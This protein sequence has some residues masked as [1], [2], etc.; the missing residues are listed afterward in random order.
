MGIFTRLSDIINSNINA[1][2]DH[3]EDPEKI[4]RMIIQEMEDTLVEAR[5]TAARTIAERKDAERQLRRYREAQDEW[6]RKAEVALRKGREDLSKAA[7]IEKSKLGESVTALETELEALD[8]ALSQGDA[9]ITKLEAKLREVKARQKAM[10]TRSD[11]ASNRL[12]ARKHTYDSRVEDA[13]AR[14]ESVERRIDRL[15]G[16]V[17][18]YDVGR[19][20]TLTEEIADLEA[21]AEIEDE[22]AALK[23]RVAKNGETA[24]RK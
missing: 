2:L 13:F 17:E 21:E 19:T 20:K 12:K 6:V 5:A 22:L 16:E 1:I 24:E 11:T 23:A 15:E 10:Q 4:I 8:T 3:A 18:A 14:F 9:D 7:L